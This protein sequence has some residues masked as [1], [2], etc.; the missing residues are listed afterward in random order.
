[1][2]EEKIITASI[3]TT[4]RIPE[5]LLALLMTSVATDVIM[6]RVGK[7]IPVE[8]ITLPCKMWSLMNPECRRHYVIELDALTSSSLAV[9]AW[10]LSRAASWIPVMLSRTKVPTFPPACSYASRRAYR[11]ALKFQSSPRHIRRRIRGTTA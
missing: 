1:M 2:R 11:S 8:V 3:A 6:S 7:G 9:F 5:R 4:R 10:S